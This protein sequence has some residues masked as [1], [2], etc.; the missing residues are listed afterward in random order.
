M[1][2]G[3]KWLLDFSLPEEYLLGIECNTYRVVSFK[4]IEVVLECFEFILEGAE[5]VPPGNSVERS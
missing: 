3:R 1:I 2:N 5:P 4:R